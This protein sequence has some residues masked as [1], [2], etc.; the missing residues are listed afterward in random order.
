MVGLNQT[1]G[2]GEKRRENNGDLMGWADFIATFLKCGYKSEKCV[3]SPSWAAFV[4]PPRFVVVT[5]CGLFER[6]EL[7]SL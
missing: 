3:L 5:S 4:M 6:G 7:G 2:K 1:M